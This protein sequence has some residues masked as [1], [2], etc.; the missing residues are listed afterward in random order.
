MVKFDIPRNHRLGELVQSTRVIEM[1]PQINVTFADK[2]ID[3]FELK[4]HRIKADSPIRCNY[5]GHLRSNRSSIVAVT[6]CLDKP[7][8]RMEITM[9]SE[10]TKNKMYTVDYNGK[11]EPLKGPFEGGGFR[12]FKFN[13]C[14]SL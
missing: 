14:F 13:M 3:N 10:K 4:H 7:G 5:L 1:P 9:F 12:I 8:D 11:T 6:G 2:S